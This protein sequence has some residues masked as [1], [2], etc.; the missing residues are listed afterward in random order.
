MEEKVRKGASKV[1]GREGKVL[2]FCLLMILRQTRFNFI[3]PAG[4]TAEMFFVMKASGRTER[5]LPTGD[6]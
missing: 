2:Q 5:T 6:F 3:R 4:A 1:K